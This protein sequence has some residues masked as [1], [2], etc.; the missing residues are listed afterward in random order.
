MTTQTL[1]TLAQSVTIKTR[2][3][4]KP[5][6][7]GG[8]SRS[9][10]VT[11]GYQGRTFSFDFWQGAAHFNPPTAAD[12]LDCLLSDASAAEQ[13]FEDWCSDIGENSDSRKAEQTWKQCAKL[14]RKLKTL[15][16]DHYAAFMQ[17][18]RD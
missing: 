8:E 17:A 4:D 7:W 10:R 3:T 14:G 9:W 2:R 15:L 5:S 11:L 6:P 16:G 13:T 1:S 18:E 12:C